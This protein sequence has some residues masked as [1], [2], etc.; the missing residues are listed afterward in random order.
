M[1]LDPDYP[2][3]NQTEITLK[4]IS[5]LQVAKDDSNSDDESYMEEAEDRMTMSWTTT[6]SWKW[7]TTLVQMGRICR[8]TTGHNVHEG[9]TADTKTTPNS[10]SLC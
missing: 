10:A 5:P 7:M 1:R 8:G 4:A 6:W 3:N 9:Q 2:I